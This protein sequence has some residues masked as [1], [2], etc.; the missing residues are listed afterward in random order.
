L[1]ETNGFHLILKYGYFLFS[2]RK[3]Q[4]SRKRLY[5]VENINDV[6]TQDFIF[7][8]RFK[9]RFTRHAA[10][11]LTLYVFLLLTANIPAHLFPNWNI[12]YNKAFVES[13]GG[14]SKMLLNRLKG[15]ELRYFAM[16]M[17]FTYCI[18][19][20]LLPAYFDRKRKWVSA[21]VLVLLLFITL[22]ALHYLIVYQ[23][24]LKAISENIRAGRKLPEQMR[25]TWDRIR[26][27]LFSI[28]FNLAIVV[29]FAV[30]IKLMKRWWHKLK[31]TEELAREKVK[32]ELQLLKAQIHPHF[33]FNTLNNIY[34]FTLNASPHAPL[35]IKKLSGMLHYILHECN[36]VLVPLE[37]ELKMLEDYIAL[38]RIRYNERL[39]MRTTVK[40]ET[41]NKFIAPL[42]LIP[43]VENCFKHGAS[44]MI[45]DSAITMDIIIE[46]NELIF[47]INNS[48][49]LQHEPTPRQS[50]LGLKNVKKRLELLYPVNHQLQIVSEQ[51]SF[52]VLLKISL[53]EITS[54]KT[55]TE[56]FKP[57][58]NYA[59][60]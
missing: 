7:S 15:Q 8:N 29:G 16:H 51:G 6:T 32:A 60:A 58:L 45:A 43:F 59:M 48:K 21:T 36:L 28:T 41:S 23:N 26:V 18:I 44:K 53:S 34:Y 37:K 4:C 2:M 52:A 19:Y 56:E 30:A 17:T 33:L 38:E 25:G 20:F 10:F 35:M 57:P 39:Q 27:V 9:Y 42:L 47:S 5:L 50:G 22:Q 46:D 54:S 55:I 31:E 14:L 11:W 40:G 1:C 24:Q 12:E 49:P 3:G 13:K